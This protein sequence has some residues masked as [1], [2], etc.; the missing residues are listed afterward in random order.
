MILSTLILLCN[1]YDHL[2][3]EFFASCK[4]ETLH[5]YYVWFLPFLTDEKTKAQSGQVTSTFNKYLLSAYF[6]ASTLLGLEAADLSKV[7]QL[8]VGGVRSP[9][10]DSRNPTLKQDVVLKAQWSF[11]RS[12]LFPTRLW[13][14]VPG[15]GGTGKVIKECVTPAVLTVT[16]EPCHF[17][18]QYHRQLYHKC[19]HRGWPGPDPGKTT[20]EGLEQ[21]SG[22]GGLCPSF[23]P[24]NPA[25][26][27]GAVIGKGSPAPWAELGSFI[28]F[29]LSF[30][31]YW[32]IVDLQYCVGFRCT[33][34][35]FSYI[36]IFF[37]I[38]FHYKLLQDIEYSS[39][40][41]TVNPCCL[42][43]L[44]IVVCIC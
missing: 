26:R 37:Q 2:S 8:V 7:T 5:L 10:T 21:G 13:G 25:W 1:H 18:F 40:Y 20:P 24:R 3:P 4:T 15:Q 43:I 23:C 34:K 16:R 22:G 28:S 30:F 33:A 29:F 14:V 42:S 35:W 12:I 44:C 39:L 38:I 19:I 9:P 32:S 36:Y 11:Q 41:Y 27:E 17:P 6:V 31:I